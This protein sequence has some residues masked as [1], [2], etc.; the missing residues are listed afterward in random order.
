[1]RSWKSL[2]F[3]TFAM[4]AILAVTFAEEEEEV[5]EERYTSKYDYIDVDDILGN[6]KLRKQYE[7]CYLEEGPCS[8]PESLYFKERFPDAFTTNCKKCTPKQLEF[9]D[10]VVAWY[11]EN[12]PEL[13][14]TIVERTLNK[15]KER[16]EKKKLKQQQQ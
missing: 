13:W 2:L 7:K 5:S 9:F 1:M 10:K 11:T 8:T 3:M 12:E 16:A 6:E 15:A 14:K 4:S